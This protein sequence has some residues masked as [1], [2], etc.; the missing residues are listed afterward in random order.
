M[1]DLRNGSFNL[2][3]SGTT[4]PEITIESKIIAV[5]VQGVPPE[6]QWHKA[7]WLN[8]VF[9]VPLN[10]TKGQSR[11][12]YFGSQLL[13]FQFFPYLLKFERHPWTRAGSVHLT[14]WEYVGSD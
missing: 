7:G 10:P 14:V 1:T 2:I 13:V 12:V 8:Q 11:Q 6:N 9:N 3:I 4:I 5:R